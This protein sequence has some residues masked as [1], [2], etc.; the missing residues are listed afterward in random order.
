M[1]KTL[2]QKILIVMLSSIPTAMAVNMNAS[3]EEGKNG[4]REYDYEHFKGV[5]YLKKK[6]KIMLVAY[7]VE[8]S[9]STCDLVKEN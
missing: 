6:N 4:T 8:G 9:Y 5:S 2:L 7:F 1:K 3:A